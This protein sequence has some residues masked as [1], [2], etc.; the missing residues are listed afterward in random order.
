M[1]TV[2]QT[3]TYFASSKTVFLQV[4]RK[5]GDSEPASEENKQFDLGGK[6]GSHRFEKRMYWY[7]F[8][9]LWGNSGL[10]CPACVLCFCLSAC[11]VSV[12]FCFLLQENQVMIIFLRAGGNVGGE[13]KIYEDVNQVD[14]ERNR[15]ASIFLPINPLKIK[16]SRFGSIATRW[17]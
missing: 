12:S 15:R 11:F 13:K 4:S 1:Q 3:P 2:S 10:G 5:P 14:E 6:E 7:Y 17:G 9:F 8:L 16:T